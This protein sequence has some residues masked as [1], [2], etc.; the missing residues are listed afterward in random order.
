MRFIAFSTLLLELACRPPAGDRSELD[1]AAEQLAQ[2]PSASWSAVAVEAPLTPASAESGRALFLRYCAGC[3][4]PAGDGRGQ[5][6]PLLRV[7]P[8]DLTRGEFDLQ[9]STPGD[10]PQPADIFRT[11][12]AGISASGMPSFARLAAADRW[13]LA[14]YVRTLSPRWRTEAE[15]RPLDLREDGAAGAADGAE[16]YRRAACATCHGPGGRGDGPS[17][18]DLAV[19]PTDL[20]NPA[21]FKG[22]AAAPDVFRTLLTGLSRSSMPSYQ[23]SGLSRA[24]L[25]ALAEHVATLA[26]NG[27]AERVQRW[28]GFLGSLGFTA[29]AKQKAGENPPPAHPGADGCLRCHSDVAVINDKMQPALLAFAAGRQSG[30]C[31][32]CHEGNADG[33]SEPAAHRGLIANPGSL[34]AVGLGMGCAKCH[35]TAA[36]LATFQRKPLPEPVGGRLMSV[37]S[38]VSDPTGAT[39]FGHAYRVPRALMAAELGKATTALLANGIAPVG[40]MGFA[41]V[42][43]DD[44]DGP[45]PVVGSP[46]YRAWVGRAIDRKFLRHLEG[47][48]V[49]PG[50]TEG[51]SRFGSSANASVGELF[52]KDCARCHLWDRGVPGAGGRWRS[53]GCSACHVLYPVDAPAGAHGMA[54][55]EGTDRPLAHR[56]TAQIPSSQCAHCHWRGGGYYS[57]LHYERGL[58][59]ADC[60][61]SVDVHGDGNIYPTMHLQVEVACED[62]HGTTL[63]YPWELPVGYG[64]P[65]SLAGGRGVATVDGTDYLMTSRGNAR[66]AWVRRGNAAVV[67][68]Q[69][70]REHVIPLL[71]NLHQNGGWATEAGRVAMDALPV[72]EEKLECL[73]CHVKKVVQCQG[74]HATVDMRGSGVDWT[75]TV[76]ARSSPWTA[77]EHPPSPGHAEFSPS[78]RA[79]VEPPLG[80][81]LQGRV[82]ALVPGCLLSVDVTAPDG[83][84]S[85]LDGRGLT[86]EGRP[87]ATLAPLIPH[88]VTLAAR[89][90]ESCHTSPLALGYGVGRDKG[91]RPDPRMP[92]ERGPRAGRVNAAQWQSVPR[93]H[94]LAAGGGMNVSAALDV[95]R[96]VT[97]DGTQVK[98]LADPGEAPLSPEQ[99]EK[100]DREGSCLACHR[101]EGTKGWDEVKRRLGPAPTPEAHD[102]A[103]GE[104]LESYLHGKHP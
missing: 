56:I 6:A 53:E 99:R 81:D 101:L 31:V 85:S 26:K 4:G 13:S 59:C 79:L 66:T 2:P 43:V 64:T 20:T 83:Q 89:S 24:E 45:A 44:P 97:R 1:I 23:E 34:W 39:G 25:W 69:D 100:V 58:E 36:A 65:V 12:T 95:N 10:L 21:A 37:V 14:D 35:S 51:L 82:T 29:A 7:P 96:L 86:P 9:S 92:R 75:G 40:P 103:I 71:K 47:A 33:E 19:A 52:R 22:G 76:G 16:I 77:A 78:P 50:Y 60:H 30:T 49:I 46:A 27:R 15:G 68:G 91:S 28:R 57:D 55:F 32:L 88:A 84:R 73:A 41:D 62:C 54:R 3:H 17:A 11:V 48:E 63:S 94:G 74:C 42:P 104:I 61:G 90:C 5:F 93:T 38:K 8:A 18:R 87:R 67:I 80:L 102:R 98:N 72:H 70:G